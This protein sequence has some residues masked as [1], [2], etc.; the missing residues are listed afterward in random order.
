MEY[1]FGS[2]AIVILYFVVIE[3]I[4]RIFRSKKD[5]VVYDM[6]SE[7]RKKEIINQIEEI[8]KIIIDKKTAYEAKKEKLYEAIKQ[9]NDSDNSTSNNT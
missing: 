6:E 7:K 4:E 1:I 2:A 3:F 8:D 5:A 9:S